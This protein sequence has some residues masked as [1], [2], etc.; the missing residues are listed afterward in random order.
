VQLLGLLLVDHVGERVAELVEGQWDRAVA[1]GRVGEHGT[2]RPQRRDR[3]RQDAAERGRG[4]RDGDRGQTAPG[5][6][7]GQQPAER[8]A[9]DHGLLLQAADDFLDVVGDLPD[10]LAREDVRVRLGLLDRVRI[11]GPARGERDVAGLLEVPRPAV[12]A[13]GE[14][15]QA[16]DEDH[17]LEARCVRP[18]DLLGLLIGDRAALLSGGHAAPLGW[19]RMFSATPWRVQPPARFIAPWPG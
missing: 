13:A 1:V 6:D 15:P 16:V 18:L 11:V 8:V 3:H 10:R 19:R 12:P 7:L 4:D 5:Q 2:R 9:H 17:R 14:E